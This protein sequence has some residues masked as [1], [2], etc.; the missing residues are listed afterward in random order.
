AARAVL[1]RVLNLLEELRAEL[2]RVKAENQRLRDENNR[3]KGEQ[4]KPRMLAN[5]G[6]STNKTSD[7]C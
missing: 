1:D 7:M 2:T 4:A 5:K 3:L 6:I